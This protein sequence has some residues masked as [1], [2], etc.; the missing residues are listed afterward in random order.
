MTRFRKSAILLVLLPVLL[1]VLV[2]RF[3]HKDTPSDCHISTQAVIN[4]MDSL[5]AMPYCDI[6]HVMVMQHGEVIAEMHPAPFRANDKH[7]LYS[8]SKTFV[9]MAV[10]IAADEGLL[11]L[12][13]K[14]I[15]FF[16][17]KVP[18]N[19]SGN[20]AAMTVRDLLTMTSGIEPDK[21]MRDTS[22][23]WVKDWLAKN[24]ADK[25]GTRFQY[26]SMCSFMLSAIVQR[27]SGRTLLDYLNEKLLNPMGCHEVDWEMSPDGINTGGWGMRADTETMAKLGQLLLNKGN[28]KGPQLVSAEYVE[29]ACSRQNNG[30]AVISVPPTD[31]N[32]GYGYQVWRCKWPGSYRASGA[33]GQVTVVV[34]EYDLVVVIMGMT[35]LGHTELACIWNQLLSGIYSGPVKHEPDLEKAL[36]KR[37]EEASLHK[38]EGERSSNDK[39]VTNRRLIMENNAYGVLWAQVDGDTLR[40][41]CAD[42]PVETVPMGFQEWRYSEMKGYP[43]YTITALNRMQDLKHDFV[44]GAAYAWTSP[45]TIEIRI[46]YVNWISGTAFLFDFD[47]QEMIVRDSY[48]YSEPQFIKFTV[49]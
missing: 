28:W 21:K 39:K 30:G 36:K 29:E 16:P 10:G 11:H 32:Q 5:M 46:H 22:T 7:T 40:W 38:P 45:T 33:Y 48:P 15:S 43:P 13:D 37:C 1:V 9:S 18:D 42:K 3:A 17:D 8:A 19:I 23:D 34:P 35:V 6:H 25:P 47:K 24:V 31:N 4:M 41:Q 49:E 12:T 44:A 14:V 27:V 20:L 2:D 26:D